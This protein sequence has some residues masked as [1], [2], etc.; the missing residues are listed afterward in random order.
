MQYRNAFSSKVVIYTDCI[1]STL[2]VFM[3]LKGLVCAFISI[4]QAIKVGFVKCGMTAAAASE[5]TNVVC[6]LK[7][8]IRE[9]EKV[10]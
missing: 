2:Q 4:L 10:P 3:R 1:S 8:S 7:S 5:L 9:I 6:D